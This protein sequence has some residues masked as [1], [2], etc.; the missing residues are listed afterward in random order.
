MT[1]SRPCFK[2]IPTELNR[3]RHCLWDWSP[4][5]HSSCS[6]QRPVE[7]VRRSRRL[8]GK[9]KPVGAGNATAEEDEP[10][11]AQSAVAEEDV[12]AGNAVPRPSFYGNSISQCKSPMMMFVNDATHNRQDIPSLSRRQVAPAVQDEIAAQS[13]RTA[14]PPLRPP[15]PVTPPSPRRYTTPAARSPLEQPKTPER[16]KDKPASS[17]SASSQGKSA[18][19]GESPP[20]GS[21]T[22]TLLSCACDITNHANCSIIP[23]TASP[24][25]ATFSAHP[26]CSRVI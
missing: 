6:L 15:H 19:L 3:K 20:G 7:P 16:E 9:G 12:I 17:S 21:G 13:S 4:C 5:S 26:I 2:R 10:A 22:L 1:S 11:E 18:R 25:T 8:G 23:S 14:T 24:D